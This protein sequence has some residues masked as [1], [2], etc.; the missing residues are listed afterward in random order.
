M[1]W[2]DFPC[3]WTGRINIKVA[4]LPKT[5]YTLNSTPIKI[6]IIFFTELF[7]KLLKFVWNRKRPQKANMILSKK[8]HNWKCYIIWTQ[9]VLQSH[10]NKDNMLLAQNRNVNQWNIIGNPEINPHSSGCLIFLNVP[11][12]YTRKKTTSTMMVL[13]KLDIHL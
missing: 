8:I 2:K 11:K 6:P 5:V 1:W 13:V 3:S 9:T 4:I 10:S 7:L 12:I